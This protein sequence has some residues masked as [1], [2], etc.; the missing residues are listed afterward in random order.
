VI[1]RDNS[2]LFDP[3]LWM[4]AD[5]RAEAVDV[6]VPIRDFQR[7]RRFHLLHAE[8]RGIDLEHREVQ[9]DE[10]SRPYDYLVIALGSVTELPSLPGL[11]E[12]VRP[13]RTPV[14][15][16]ELRDHLIDAVE[17]AHRATDETERRA[18][19]TFVV[20]G[21]GDT[22]VELAG[23]LN[24][25]LGAGL[26]REY[27]WLAPAS[28]GPAYRIVLVGRAPRLLPMAD[29]AEA[30][31]THHALE[32]AG[33]EIQTGTA[34]QEVRPDA[35][36]TSRGTIPAR[37]IFWAAGIAPPSVLRDLPVKHAKGG[38]LVVDDRLRLPDHPEVHVVGDS[39]W[40]FDATGRAVPP[41]AQAAEITGAYAGRDI[42]AQVAGGPSAGPFRFAPLGHLALLGPGMAIVRIG[43]ILLTGRIAWLGWHA[44]YIYRIPS[45][46]RR[47]A[48]LGT[49]GLSAVFGREVAQVRA[50]RSDVERSRK[51]PS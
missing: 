20:A 6:E 2:T 26:L 8:V 10:G 38:T 9:L 51:V 50:R 4:V 46:K 7:G 37:T 43:P 18:W 25:Y 30:E 24:S 44:Y 11:A 13:F 31:A 47:I 32:R 16:V 17:A 34:V 42:A 36:V 12:N 28:G 14:D 40:A 1:D 48:L 27:P 29:A 41:T 5:G 45:W 15:A 23:A 3:L 19:L 39:A 49:W 33:I 35:V 21:G 22:G